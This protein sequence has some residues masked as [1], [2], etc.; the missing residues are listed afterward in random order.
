MSKLIEAEEQAM[1]IAIDGHG[2]LNLER[3][4][5]MKNSVCPFASA[6]S[7][8]YCGDWCPHFGEPVVNDNTS[9]LQITCGDG[10]MIYGEIADNRGKP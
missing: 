8:L 2:Y 9:F 7:F 10:K 6:D 5:I 4:G 3:A 1:R